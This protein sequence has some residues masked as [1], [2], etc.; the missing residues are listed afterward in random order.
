MHATKQTGWV[1]WI[2]QASEVPTLGSWVTHPLSVL[3]SVPMSHPWNKHQTLYKLCTK[4]DMWNQTWYHLHL[5]ATL[6]YNYTIKQ[7]GLW[8]RSMGTSLATAYYNLQTSPFTAFGRKLTTLPEWL[9]CQHIPI[10]CATP[11]QETADTAARW[12]TGAGGQI[13]GVDT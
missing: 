2:A 12:G 6:F 1:G 5:G 3:P 13:T 7:L 8:W 11:T 4:Q 9:S 10:A